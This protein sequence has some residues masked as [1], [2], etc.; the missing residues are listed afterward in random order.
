[1]KTLKAVL[2]VLAALAAT[3]AGLDVSGFIALMP[4]DVAKVLVIVPSAAAVV[5]HLIEGFRKN[6]GSDDAG[7]VQCHPLVVIFAVIFAVLI[8][9]ACTS[10]TTTT[11]APDGTVT[12]TKTES[13]DPAT[14]QAIA[15]TVKDFAPPRARLVVDAGGK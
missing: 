6:L 15:G 1:M 10:V 5:V 4:P 8:V 12:V 14:V 7:K 3:L 2:A 9:S 13:V 11:T